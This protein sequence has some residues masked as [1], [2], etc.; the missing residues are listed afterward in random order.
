MVSRKDVLLRRTNIKKRS[1]CTFV[2][3]KNI[4]FLCSHVAQ[5]SCLIYIMITQD[6]YYAIE[7]AFSTFRIINFHVS[8]I[9][10]MERD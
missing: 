9:K 5:V 8:L 6:D 1:Y 3:K 7:S 2:L 10:V 4:L